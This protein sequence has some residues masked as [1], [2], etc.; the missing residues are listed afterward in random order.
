MTLSQR[1][2]EAAARAIAEARSRITGGTANQ[3]PS[4]FIHAEAAIEAA[5]AVDGLCLVPKEPTEGMMAAGGKKAEDIFFRGEGS[6]TTTLDAMKDVWTAM[7][8]APSDAEDS[9]RQ[10]KI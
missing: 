4:D 7:I 5:L 10:E 1:A 6:K 9:P 8:S 3:I 2:V